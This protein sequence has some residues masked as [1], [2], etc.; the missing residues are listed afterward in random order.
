MI[1]SRS[2]ISRDTH[3]WARWVLTAGFA[4]NVGAAL[5]QEVRVGRADCSEPVHLVAREAPLSSVLKRLAET[6][7]FELVYQSQRDLLVTRNER[8]PVTDLVR[9]LAH[10]MNFSIEQTFDRR[11]LYNQRLAKISVLPDTGDNT[12]PSTAARALS[13]TPEMDRIARQQMSDYLRSHGMEDQSI[14]DIA[15]R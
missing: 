3:L 13:Q 14:E 7:G 1:S 9:D 2:E 4:L 11:C 5:A 10:D 6:L 12:R 15:V 8:L